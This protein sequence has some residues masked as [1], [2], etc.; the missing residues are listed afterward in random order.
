MTLPR[1]PRAAVRMHLEFD[2]YVNLRDVG[3]L[4]TLL[5]RLYDTFLY[6]FVPELEHRETARLRLRSIREG[7][8]IAELATGIA[9]V[10]GSRERNASTR[11][12]G[13]AALRGLVGLVGDVA[14]RALEF[15]HRRQELQTAAERDRIQLAREKLAL[16]REAVDVAERELEYNRRA[17]QA[18]LDRE[19]GRREL[20]AAMAERNLNLLSL[21]ERSL[22]THAEAAHYAVNQAMVI[23]VSRVVA[24]D[25]P[26]LQ[27]LFVNGQFT[28][29]TFEDVR[30]AVE[31]PPTGPQP[32]EGDASDSSRR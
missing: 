27:Q 3:E 22:S 32:I 4:F 31:P 9:Q 20:D 1:A 24:A 11:T 16:R 25:L 12:N 26:H 29:L 14:D 2:S 15:R 18:D 10:T 23:E 21:A 28:S 13:P 6:G 8:L 5:D 7:S 19:A 17:D 30:D